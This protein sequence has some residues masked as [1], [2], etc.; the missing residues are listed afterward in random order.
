MTR[1]ERKPESGPT[2]SREFFSPPKKY[3]IF[4]ERQQKH[5]LMFLLAF[6]L[7]VIIVPKGG[8]VPD[9][10]AP[11][12]IAS[13]DIKSPRDLLIPDLPLTEQKRLEAEGAVPAL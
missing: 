4:E 9:Y 10:Y 11:G 7:T 3:F 6:V 13:R 2:R 1:Q 8:F 5:L 12:D